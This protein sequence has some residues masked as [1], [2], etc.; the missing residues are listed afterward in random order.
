[1]SAT[2]DPLAV[3]AAGGLVITDLTKVPAAPDES[4]WYRHRPDVL[5][6]ALRAWQRRDVIFTLAERD[7]R[8]AYKQVVLGFGWAVLTPVLSMLVFSVLLGHVKSFQVKGVPYPLEVYTGMWAWGIFGGALGGGAGS[9]I[10]NKSM[11]AKTHFPRECFPLSQVVES[12]FTSALA[13]VPLVILFAR[14]TYAPK[15]A[16]LWVPLYLAIELIFVVGVVLLVSSVIVQARDLQ[17]VLPMFMQ[18]GMLLTPIIWPMGRFIRGAF[19]PIYSFVNP[20]GPVI[21][22][23]KGS[24]LLG[25]RPHFALLAI[26][27]CGALTYLVVGYRVFK[28]LEVNFADLA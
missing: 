18:F 22:G 17:Q 12:A 21:D 4:Q 28:R 25:N 6:S 26:G 5:G 11:M 1:V 7:I 2:I 9:L 19:V 10:A 16:T 20:M 13:L 14:Y 8:A 24:M 15:L 23:M 3:E 27:L